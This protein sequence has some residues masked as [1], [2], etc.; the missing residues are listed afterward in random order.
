MKCS[1]ILIGLFLLQVLLISCTTNLS[2]PTIKDYAWVPYTSDLDGYVTCTYFINDKV[3][4]S[5][6]STSIYKTV[7]GGIHWKVVNTNERT[8]NSIYF[9]NENLGFAVGGGGTEFKNAGSLIYKTIDAGAT[10]VKI[11][12]VI[13][14]G[15]DLQTVF[16]SNENIGFA[17]GLG[18]YIKTIDGGKTWTN[19]EFESNFQGILRK[20]SFKDL[21]TGF[22][23]GT[24]GSIYK[25]TDQGVKW[26]K[27]QNG[28]G[29]QIYDFC[30]VNSTGYA[31]RMGKIIKSTDNG[32]TWSELSDSPENVTAIYFKDEKIGVAIGNGHFVVN[33]WT[34]ALFY[35]KDGGATWKMDDT[36]DFSTI[37]HFP[38][39]TLGFSIG[40]K[41]TVKIQLAK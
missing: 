8:I 19:L 38:T 28:T 13:T 29:G 36:F 33:R 25:T 12:L 1:R 15:S 41:S 21:Q 32:D 5:A 20:I 3:G 27:V 26:T 23:G 16:F 9:V 34:K 10:W 14:K 24:D 37:F 17:V 18:L 22:A 7:D 30:F 4:F 39:S 31:A 40:T 11:P 35:T 2:T 6:G